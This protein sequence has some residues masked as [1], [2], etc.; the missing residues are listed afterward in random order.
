MGT[1]YISEHTAGVVAGGQVVAEPAITE[2]TVSIGATS[3]ASSPFNEGTR[4][5]RVHADSIC[6]VAINASPTA[7][8]SNKR[9]AANQTEYFNVLPGNSIAVI[10]NT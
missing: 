10:E 1:L 4:M 3:A 8:T 2:Q 7:T 5:I 9:F 6:S